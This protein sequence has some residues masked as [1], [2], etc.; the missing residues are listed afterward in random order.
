VILPDTGEG[1]F[2]VLVQLHGLTDDA[3]AWI[4][5]SNLVR[6]VAGLPLVVVLPD[7]GTSGYVNWK[8]AG[9]LHRNRYEDLVVRDIPAISM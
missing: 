9:R 3:D 7:G 4:Q 5:R 6:H 2:P 8:S 1:P